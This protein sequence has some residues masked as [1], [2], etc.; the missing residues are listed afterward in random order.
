MTPDRAGKQ[1]GFCLVCG[2][3]KAVLYPQ[4]GKGLKGQEIHYCGRQFCF[5]CVRITDNWTASKNSVRFQHRFFKEWNYVLQEGCLICRK[6][7]WYDVS[8]LLGIDSPYWIGKPKFE[9]NKTLQLRHAAWEEAAA[10]KE[11][12]LQSWM[13][14]EDT[15]DI[16]S[17]RRLL[18]NLDAEARFIISKKNVYA[19]TVQER[20]K[21]MESEATEGDG[22]DLPL[23]ALDAV[24]W[25]NA[26]DRSPSPSEQ[27]DGGGGEEVD[28]DTIFVRSRTPS[29]S[30][31]IVAATQEKKCDTTAR[32]KRQDNIPNFSSNTIVDLT[33]DDDA[34]SSPTVRPALAPLAPTRAG[35]NVGGTLPPIDDSRTNLLEQ[36]HGVQRALPLSGSYPNGTPR[37]APTRFQIPLSNAPPEAHRQY[38]I[39]QQR[40]QRMN[41]SIPPQAGPSQMQQHPRQDQNQFETTAK[42]Q[43][44][45]IPSQGTVQV[46]GRTPLTQP[47]A[48]HSASPS[49]SAQSIPTNGPATLLQQGSRANGRFVSNLGGQ[50]TIALQQALN[51]TQARLQ[52][53]ETTCS[54]LSLERTK[55]MTDVQLAQ[56]QLALADRAIKHIRSLYDKQHAL[57][58]ALRQK[59]EEAKQTVASPDMFLPHQK[60]KPQ[61][62]QGP[63]L[64]DSST[65]GSRP[66]S[67]MM[68]PPHTLGIS[69]DHRMQG[70][71][72][73]SNN[74][75]TP[76]QT[77][78]AVSATSTLSTASAQYTSQSPIST[79]PLATQSQGGE[80]LTVSESLK[81]PFGAFRASLGSHWAKYESLCIA[82]ARHQKAWDMMVHTGMENENTSSREGR[83]QM[84]VPAKL[85]TVD[86]QVIRAQTIY[87]YEQLDT[88]FKQALYQVG[89]H[90]DLLKQGR[91]MKPTGTLEGGGIHG[92][93]ERLAQSSTQADSRT[94]GGAASPHTVAADRTNE[95]TTNVERPDEHAAP[96]VS[97]PGPDKAAA[98]LRT[99]AESGEG[100]STP[101]NTTERPARALPAYRFVTR[102]PSTTAE[103]PP[104]AQAPSKVSCNKRKADDV[105]MEDAANAKKIKTEQGD[106]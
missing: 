28:E 37:K 8:P 25:L 61:T 14:L 65:Q 89:N 11:R 7:G 67:S 9:K 45:S 42:R 53:S 16:E 24:S 31:E 20:Q 38:R 30:V 12:K 88:L 48:L 97:T 90:A 102:S 81:Q 93:A 98:H 92:I 57:N 21:I 10:G 84:H 35:H 34:P 83:V 18:Y 13:T 71:L 79:K 26:K 72:I 4:Q 70:G 77:S 36:G 2:T 101:T 106:E 100:T 49:N 75:Q 82:N 96:A 29:E 62:A 105:A 56:S 68:L 76:N 95:P 40:A 58:A 39:D 41:G 47:A 1:D 51:I 69:Q 33:A 32:A 91:H 85:P 59:L 5:K 44:Q 50:P 86:A 66:R 73:A 104:R 6:R 80:A 94:P 64:Q 74:A 46:G 3:T 23:A 52:A 22:F 87:E 19:F 78:E 54:T 43:Q 99:S 17:D 103:V 27:E 60:P 15:G 63:N 55:L